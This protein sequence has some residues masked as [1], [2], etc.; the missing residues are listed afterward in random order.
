MPLPSPANATRLTG[1][2]SETM[3]SAVRCVL[4]AIIPDAASVD[5]IT[6]KDTATV[7]AGSVTVIWAPI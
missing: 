4:H 3:I 1:V 7:G 2:I 5:V 6:A